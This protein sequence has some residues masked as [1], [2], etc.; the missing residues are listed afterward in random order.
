[1]RTVSIQQTNQ[2]QIRAN[3]TSPQVFFKKLFSNLTT[4][5]EYAELTGDKWLGWVG[6]LVKNQLIKECSRQIRKGQIS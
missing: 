6:I 3:P 4:L 1:M 5:I 2:S